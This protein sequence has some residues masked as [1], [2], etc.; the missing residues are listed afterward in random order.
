MEENK[1]PSI[2]DKDFKELLKS[3]PKSIAFNVIQNEIEL[4]QNDLDHFVKSVQST[5]EGKL[6]S[7]EHLKNIFFMWKVKQ[8]QDEIK[9][10]TTVK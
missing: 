5:K 1:K 3:D 9:K 8:L 6:L 2:E 7:Y 10:L 4:I